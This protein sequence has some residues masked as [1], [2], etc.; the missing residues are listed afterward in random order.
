MFLKGRQCLLGLPNYLRFVVL[1]DILGSRKFCNH[2]E[3]VAVQKSLRTP[4]LRKNFTGC[5]CF[6]KFF[7]DLLKSQ[8]VS[9]IFFKNVISAKKVNKFKSGIAFN[10]NFIGG[11]LT[12]NTFYIVTVMQSDHNN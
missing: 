6:E 4:G 7:S 1:C 5:H 2:L 9:N 8:K 3:R 10:K 12:L 11:W